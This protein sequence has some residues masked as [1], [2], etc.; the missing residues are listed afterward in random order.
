M[1]IQGMERVEKN[2]VDQV[3]EATVN[4][5]LA[6]VPANVPAIAFLY[7]GH[8]PK[9]ASAHLNAVNKYFK[10]RLFWIVT[11]SFARSIQQP[12][13]EA[14]KGKDE[15]VEEAQKLLYK[16][17]KLDAAARRGEYNKDMEK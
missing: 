1:V 9:V 5:L 15:N 4:C 11:F 3:A 12:A 2:S 7:V 8:S 10:D 17:A 14:W 6:T 16:R 13:L